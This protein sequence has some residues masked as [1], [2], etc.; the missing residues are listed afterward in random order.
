MHDAVREGITRQLLV[1]HNI[2]SHTMKVPVEGVL[3]SQAAA[4]DAA[5]AAAKHFEEESEVPS[6]LWLRMVAAAVSAWRSFDGVLYLSPSSFSRSIHS[7]ST[8]ILLYRT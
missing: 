6:P 3:V 4:V 8:S 2:V 7:S 1:S 5:V